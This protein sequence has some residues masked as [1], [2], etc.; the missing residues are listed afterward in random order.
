VQAIANK[1]AARGRDVHDGIGVAVDPDSLFDVQVKRIHEYKRQHLNALQVVAR[2]LAHPAPATTCAR[3]AHVH[4]RRQGGPGLRHG[5]ADHPA[6]STASP[7]W[8]TPIPAMARPAAGGV[9]AQLQRFDL[10]QLVY[11]AADL[12]EQISTAGKEASGT[13]NMKFALNGAAHHRHPRRRQHRNPRA[14]R[15]RRTS[16]CLAITPARSKSSTATVITRRLAGERTQG[17]RSHASDQHGFFS[18]GDGSLFAAP[19]WPTS[20][21]P[22]PSG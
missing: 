11:P 8:S 20:R 1:R 22:I 5:Q 19:R 15:R 3:A 4:L 14:G 16:S 13:G 21:A 7:M 6:R 12:S 10:A 17:A 18:E 2:Y 9:P